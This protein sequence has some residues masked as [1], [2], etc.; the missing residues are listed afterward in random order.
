MIF[1]CD[2][3]SFLQ[4]VKRSAKNTTEIKLQKSWLAILNAIGVD[5][6][7]SL[8]DCN[9]KFNLNTIFHGLENLPGR[10]KTLSEF[11]GHLR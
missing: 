2:A 1:G 3:R 6:F 11:R 8:N 9:R 5:C 10:L 4:F 7:K